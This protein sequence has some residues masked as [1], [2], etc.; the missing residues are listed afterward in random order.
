MA[1]TGLLV[2]LFLF[3]HMYGNLKMFMGQEAYNHYAHWL[4]GT[5]GVEGA[6]YP[7]LPNGGAVWLER[8]GMLVIV[9]LHIFSAVKLWARGN[10]ARGNIRYK[11]TAGT[12]VRAG[13]TYQT[14]V[15]RYG[16]VVIAVWLIFHLMQFT[17]LAVQPGGEYSMDDP[18]TNM[19][20]AFQVWWVWAFYLI[21]LIAIALH[22]RHGVFSALATLG[23]LTRNRERGFKAAGNVVAALLVIGF[24]APPT[25]ILFGALS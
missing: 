16:G 23:L 3:V 22:V 2:I 17:V 6:L 20:L 10:Q 11:V 24:M 4:K 18:Y 14:T 7:L 21:A 9:V 8:I 19:I 15:M 12:K 13:K 1:V 25:A 5:G